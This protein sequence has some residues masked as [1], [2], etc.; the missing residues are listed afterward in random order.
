MCTDLLEDETGKKRMWHYYRKFL[1][2]NGDKE[3]LFKELSDAG[4][5]D[6]SD[7]G[8]EEFFTSDTSTFLITLNSKDQQYQIAFF[9][10]LNKHLSWVPPKEPAGEEQ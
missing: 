4:E 1:R 3:S 9:E 8:F 2:N 6:E 10:V 5:L 7:E